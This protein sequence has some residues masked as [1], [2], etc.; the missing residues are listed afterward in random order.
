MTFFYQDGG[1]RGV[2]AILQCFYLENLKRSV[3]MR[4]FFLIILTLYVL[5]NVQL[6]FK[7]GTRTIVFYLI[8]VKFSIL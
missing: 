6:Q 4:T 8:E 1:N 5:V 7:K 3:E 2:N